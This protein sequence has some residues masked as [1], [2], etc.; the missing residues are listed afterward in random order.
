MNTP[1]HPVVEPSPR[2][3]AQGLGP[4]GW[5]PPGTGPRRSSRAHRRSGSPGHGHGHVPGPGHP[6]PGRGGGPGGE[7]LFWAFAQHGTEPTPQEDIFAV[8]TATGAVRRLTDNS[9]GVPFVSDRD[10]AWSPARDRIV[11]MSAR[12]DEPTHLSILSAA[13][14]PVLDLPVEG[15]A[16]SWLDATTVLCHMWRDGPAGSMDRSDVVAVSVPAGLVRAG[17]HDGLG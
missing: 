12:T 7:I 13:G 17:H 14:V 15:G 16:P 11:F 9:S 6:R 3:H 5:W 8:D 2:T 4:S 1:D 10:P